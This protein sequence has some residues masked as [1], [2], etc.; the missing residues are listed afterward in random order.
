MFTEQEINKKISNQINRKV[1]PFVWTT[2]FNFVIS[3]LVFYGHIELAFQLGSIVYSVYKMSNLAYE[4]LT[5][6]IVLTL[7]DDT[8]ISKFT[9][10]ER[11]TIKIQ[12]NKD[13][14]MATLSSKNLESQSLNK[15]SYEYSYFVRIPSPLCKNS[16]LIKTYLFI[17]LF[18]V[19]LLREPF[20]YKNEL[21]EYVI[22]NL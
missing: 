14:E 11:L 9:Y 17:P 20:L 7:K 18:K 2:I 21:V 13:I 1:P 6:K 3:V 12:N 10:P 16:N 8:W 22:R 4:L 15:N 5:E 19:G